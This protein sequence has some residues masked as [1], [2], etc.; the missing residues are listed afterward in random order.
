MRSLGEGVG[1]AAIEETG[2]GFVGAVAGS[3]VVGARAD[4]GAGTRGGTLRAIGRESFLVGLH[5]MRGDGRVRSSRCPRLGNGASSVMAWRMRASDGSVV[6]FWRSAWRLRTGFWTADRGLSG[7]YRMTLVR[8]HDC[9]VAE[10]F[11]VGSIITLS[12]S[13]W[14]LRT[15]NRPG[16]YRMTLVRAHDCRIAKHFIVGSVIAL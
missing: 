6:T 7:S 14:R 10:H 11:V 8:A 9:C 2:E 15:G 5:C 13:A 3:S 1:S 4:G 16:R 12:R